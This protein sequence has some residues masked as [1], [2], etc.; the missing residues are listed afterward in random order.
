MISS[1]RLFS[2]LAHPLA[3]EQNLVSVI[4][5]NQRQVFLSSFKE[6]FKHPQA[7]LKVEGF[8]RFSREVFE[9][10]QKLC[11]TYEHKGPW[12]CHL[13][14]TPEGGYSFNEHT[15]P[16]DVVI[17]CCEGKKTIVIQGVE[18]ELVPGKCVH[19]PAG[20]PH[21]ATNKHEALTLSFGLERFLEEKI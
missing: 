12:T 10:G 1:N 17:A 2:F 20:V 3:F 8:E 21:F 11:N 14:Y 4:D 16:D 9:F 5:E 13:F 15:D 18:G 19:I 6:L 7:T